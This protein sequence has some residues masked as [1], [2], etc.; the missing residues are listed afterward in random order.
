MNLRINIPTKIDG[1]SGRQSVPT[2]FYIAGFDDLIH[3]S[4][5]ESKKTKAIPKNDAV[6]Q[7]KEEKRSTE[8]DQARRSSR[9]TDSDHKHGQFT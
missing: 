1:H 4:R 7:V 5:E 3:T 6:I 8:K 9:A 2:D